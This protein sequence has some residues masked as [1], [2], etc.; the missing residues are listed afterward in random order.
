MTTI[1]FRESGEFG[2]GATMTT[3]SVS[4]EQIEAMIADLASETGNVKTSADLQRSILTELLSLRTSSGGVTS[5]EVVAVIRFDRSPGNENE[6]PKVISCNW[7]ADGDYAL[8]AALSSLHAQPEGEKLGRFDHHPDPAIDFEIEVQS[9]EARLFDAKGGISKPG[10][11]PEDVSAVLVDIERAM[12]FRVGADPSA[13]SAKQALRALEAEAKA[14]ILQ[15]QGTGSREAVAWMHPTANWAH[16]KFSEVDIHCP[17]GGASPIPLVP[18]TQLQA[19]ER[20]AWGARNEKAK[21]K[22]QR[23]AALAR[24]KQMQD[25]NSRMAEGWSALT[26]R[27]ETVEASLAAAREALTPSGG[28]KAAYMGEFYF[29]F[30]IME[31]DEDDEPYECQR[32]V[33]VPWD[34]IKEIMAAIAARAALGSNRE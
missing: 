25:S 23:D 24:I 32:A 2:E 28:T 33:T 8:T 18:L 16:V 34:T 14:A 17:I 15:P 19:V 27:A 12:S 3:N 1:N 30:T 26:A 9:L 29:N 7:M 6:M 11:N 21:L 13:V 22:G 10:T 20:E 31:M 4:K 5:G